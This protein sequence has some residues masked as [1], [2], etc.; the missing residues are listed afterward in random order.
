M[1]LKEDERLIRGRDP[2]TMKSAIRDAF[3]RTQKDMWGEVGKK[4]N[5]TEYYLKIV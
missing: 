3:R 5:F 4:M 2:E 1:I